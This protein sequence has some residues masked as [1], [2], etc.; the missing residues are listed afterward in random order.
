MK[1]E[2][3][4][5]SNTNRREEEKTTRDTDKETRTMNH[6]NQR[7]VQWIIISIKE[8]SRTTEQREATTTVNT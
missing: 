8:D 4:R 1:Q 2:D 7:D 5:Q 3:K 6:N